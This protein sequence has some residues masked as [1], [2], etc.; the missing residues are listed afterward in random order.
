MPTK[1]A[2]GHNG[3]LYL[4]EIGRSCAWQYVMDGYDVCTDYKVNKPN[5]FHLFI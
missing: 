2:F 1:V 5:C 4:K 3:N